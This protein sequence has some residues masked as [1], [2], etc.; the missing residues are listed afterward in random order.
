LAL[1]V[2]QKTIRLG[3]TKKRL[4]TKTQTTSRLAQTKCWTITKG[5][6]YW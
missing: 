4:N 2:E 1:V 6:E 3:V 5:A